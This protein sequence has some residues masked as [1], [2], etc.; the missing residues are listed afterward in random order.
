M[1]LSSRSQGGCVVGSSGEA[2]VAPGFW[3]RS[4]VCGEE[5]RQDSRGQLDRPCLFL[6]PR[7]GENRVSG[8]SFNLGSAKKGCFPQVASQGVI[9]RAVS[10]EK[11]TKVSKNLTVLL[12][13][14]QGCSKE[15]RDIIR[16]YCGTQGKSHEG[17]GVNREMYM[18]VIQ[19][20]FPGGSDPLAQCRWVCKSWKG[21][22][23]ISCR[24]N[25]VST[26]C[27]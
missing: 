27:S 26:T 13:V 19:G 20:R 4:L 5:E 2:R 9:G 10:C 25:M 3:L 8:S 16:G 21:E 12:V 15:Q 17:T 7:P 11:R 23:H 18:E 14:I 24:W 6:L 22:K 1:R